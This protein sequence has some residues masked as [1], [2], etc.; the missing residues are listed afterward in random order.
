MAT[1][2]TTYLGDLRTEATHVQSG[3][4]IITDA[5]LDN[6]GKGEAFSPSDLLTSALGSCMLTIMGITAREQNIN[7]DGTTCSITKIMASDPRRVSEVQI[8]FNFPQENYSEK[9][10]T[11]LK[12]SA[13]TCPVAKSVHPDLIQN[14]V[15]NFGK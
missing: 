7:M 15:F 12:R 14:L 2:Q 13:E 11:I 3:N 1:I 8:S 5:P 6:K 9:D 4:V 10:K